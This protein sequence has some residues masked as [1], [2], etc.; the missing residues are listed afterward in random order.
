MAASQQ[1]PGSFSDASATLLCI[2]IFFVHLTSLFIRETKRQQ[3][4]DKNSTHADVIT[5]QL[6]E[7]SLLPRFLHLCSQDVYCVGFPCSSPGTK[8]SSKVT[9]S[10][11]TA[12]VE[13]HSTA[14]R[15]VVPPIHRYTHTLWLAQTHIAAPFGLVL[16]FPFPFCM[17]TNTIRCSS[18]NPS[19][20]AH[21]FPNWP[22][23]K[24]KRT[25]TSIYKQHT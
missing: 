19:S 18:E 6:C 2:I 23:Q 16:A 7:L 5:M 13:A 14:S 21:R 25:Y 20:N 11:G 24:Q 9:Q 12:E 10:K 8:T 22:Q 4:P 3:T 17:T 1:T 15:T